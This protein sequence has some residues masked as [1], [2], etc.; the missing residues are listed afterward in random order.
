MQGSLELNHGLKGRPRTQHRAWGRG[1]RRFASLPLVVHFASF[2]NQPSWGYN[3]K[4][5]SSP[6]FTL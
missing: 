1:V 2:L 3:N 6:N 4:C 5:E